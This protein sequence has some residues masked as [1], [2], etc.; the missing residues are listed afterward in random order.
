MTEVLRT[1]DVSDPVARDRRMEGE[2]IVK[3]LMR[4]RGVDLGR[5]EENVVGRVRGRERGRSSRTTGRHGIQI[6]NGRRRNIIVDRRE[7]N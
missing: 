2:H 5:E 7:R 6:V 3:E 1:I 4:V